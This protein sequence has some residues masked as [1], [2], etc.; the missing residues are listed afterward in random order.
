MCRHP[1]C[2]QALLQ[3]DTV[4]LL[5]K[6]LYSPQPS[7]QLQAVYALG[8][9]AAEDEAAASAIS[10]AGAVAPLTTLLLSSASVDV[11][12]TLTLT[13]AHV[14]RGE[15]K[16]VFNV[17]GFQAL[18][19]VL[20]VGNATVQQDVSSGLGL[21]LDDV[22]QRRALLADM[23]SIS[24]IVTLLSSQSV[25][26]Q[27]NAARA[28]AALAVEPQ[29]REVL[30][31]L[32]TLSHV[33]RSLSAATVRREDAVGG[34]TDESDEGARVAMLRV[35]A[36]FAAD[37]RYTSML[38]ITIQ[39]LVA[40]LA[41]DD[42]DAVAHSAA[43]VS[44]LAISHS[45]RDALREAGAPKRMAELLLHPEGTVQEHAVQCIANLG[46]DAAEATAFLRSGWHLPLISLLS[47]LSYE[48]Q[49]SAAF[50]L[51]NLALSP[52]FR[53]AMIADGALQPILQLLHAP[54]LPART[55]G[56]RAL[57]V[58]A[59]Q[60]MSTD[61]PIDDA[62]AADFVDGLFDAAAV[63]KLLE[64]LAAAA[65]PS[66]PAAAAA[67][68][69]A[70]ADAGADAATRERQLIAVLHLL[71]MLAGG[72]GHV[73][74]RL[75]ASGVVEAILRFLQARTAA[76]AASASTQTMHHRAQAALKA[77]G[78]AA[79]AAGGVS[80][81]DEIDGGAAAT[82]ALL[83]LAPEG[84]AG[85]GACG[86]A[87]ALVPLL[88]SPRAPLVSSVCRAI[89]NLAHD[90]CDAEAIADCVLPLIAVASKPRASTEGEALWGTRCTNSLWAASNLYRLR[91][92][93]PRVASAFGSPRA[94]E[95]LCGGA[96]AC[97]A[98]ATTTTPNSPNSLSSSLL[99]VSLL[100]DVASTTA[101]RAALRA[102]GAAE[103][104]LSAQ[105]KAIAG[106]GG[107]GSPPTELMALLL[108]LLS[109][110]DAA[111]PQLSSPTPPRNVEAVSARAPSPVAVAYAAPPPQPQMQPPQAAHAPP[112]QPIASAVQHYQQQQQQQQQHMQP[113]P[114]PPP[115]PPFRPSATS[116]AVC[117]A[118]ATATS[119]PPVG[120]FSA[121]EISLGPNAGAAYAAQ[122]GTPQAS[123]LAPPPPQYAQY[124]PPASQPPPPMASQPPPMA[125]QPPPMASQ[126]PP[127]ASQ[128]PPMA[129]QPPPMASQYYAPP[130]P[131]APMPPP[132]PQLL[133]PTR[134][135]QPPLIDMQAS[136][137]APP[138]VASLI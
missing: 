111:P 43:A 102:A 82:L 92:T 103:A 135:E 112:Q 31:R 1:A 60:L 68:A 44:S 54:S 30:Y 110:A 21:L 75:V 106:E 51:G 130:Q 79:A 83:L 80:T 18:L 10:L 94:L 58:M 81:D 66:E 131:A 36:A 53:S 34:V 32:G 27:Q 35:V 62:G 122:T 50:V 14:V 3:A 41:S 8:V 118:A 17:G 73:R 132:M 121:L 133:Q 85:L 137:S 107:G 115:P 119:A 138:P 45:N 23:N 33:I 25:R 129:S 5:S 125:S 76:A 40:L 127:M 67:A 39:P 97:I 22:H 28:L 74:P 56:V 6:L 84:P 126:P 37:E 89:G 46:V 113:P 123:A 104:L 63:P 12:Q 61:I 98:S 96:L 26:T 72:H 128:P 71:Q 20:S 114:P 19:E 48:T 87:A 7:A 16:L 88:R 100:M 105:T 38:R 69:A 124:A 90:G 108:G 49:A 134:P 4:P 55:A 9:M 91:H 70:A 29:A 11:K 47:A 99:A 59:Q 42:S 109:V 24:S 52:E 57:A 64:V 15:W 65:E 136:A 78:G 13:L 95:G 117:T 2:L 101:G 116:P 77:G 86:G 120:Q 93:A